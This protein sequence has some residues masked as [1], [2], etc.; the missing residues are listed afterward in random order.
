MRY[1]VVTESITPCGGSKHAIREILEIEAESPQAYVEANKRFPVM[2][3]L[4][5]TDGDTVIVTG[6]EAGYRVRYTFSE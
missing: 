4:R 2:E 5:N 3:V 6:N 1:E